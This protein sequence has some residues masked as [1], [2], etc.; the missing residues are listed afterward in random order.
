MR[1]RKQDQPFT[2]RAK[3]K[4]APKL[5]QELADGTASGEVE[6]VVAAFGIEDTNVAVGNTRKQVIDQGAFRSWLDQLDFEKDP[7]LGFVDHGGAV[8][9]GSHSARLLIGYASEAREIDEGLW[10]K[11]H[12]NLDKTVAREA[13]SDLLHNPAGVQFSFAWDPSKEKTEVRDGVEHVTQLYLTEWSQVAFGAQRAAHLVSARAKAKSEFGG[14][15][16]DALPRQIRSAW[17]DDLESIVRKVGRYAWVEEVFA[18]K[19]DGSEGYVVATF[20]D[21][22]GAKVDWAAL[23]DGGYAFD[24]D[25]AEEIEQKWVETGKALTGDDAQRSAAAVISA[26]PKALEELAGRARETSEEFGMQ[27]VT[28]L[29]KEMLEAAGSLTKTST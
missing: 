29:Y 21:G 22:R 16:L 26:S 11:T 28:E 1:F 20:E 18:T 4:D 10:L 14:S 3:V 17:Y 25:S 8:E 7:P 5:R 27:P 13:Y 2:F 15:S 23:R 6:L 19:D 12:Y 9:T 24:V